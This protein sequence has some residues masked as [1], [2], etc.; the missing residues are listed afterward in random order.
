MKRSLR[1]RLLQ[2][3]H[4]K[5]GEELDADAIETVT[6]NNNVVNQPGVI[7][8]PGVIVDTPEEEEQINNEG[9]TSQQQQQDDSTT[10]SIWDNGTPTT[11]DNN[12]N[13]QHQ[14]GQTTQQTPQQQI[15]QEA[16][17]A[18]FP[19]QP[20]TIFKNQPPRAATTFALFSSPTRFNPTTIHTSNTHYLNN[21]LEGMIYLDVN[22][23]GIR[24]S[25][26][27]RSINALEFDTG[28][29]GVESTLVHCQSNEIVMGGYP[30][31][32]IV[33]V[34]RPN[35]GES[36][37][38]EA[39][40]SERTDAG[41]YNFELSSV[42]P[43][44]YYIMYKSPKDYRLNANILPLD[45]KEGSGECLPKG[46]EGNGYIKDVYEK[47]DLDWNGYCGRTVGCFEVG[48]KVRLF[49]Y[50]LFTEGSCGLC[51][52]YLQRLILTLLHPISHTTTQTTV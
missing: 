30:L 20:E 48:P 10:N 33:D 12:G 9:S 37:V 27:D 29:G 4:G 47:G 41:L 3:I 2:L 42:K 36:V 25:T 50:V 21:A 43:G 45:R 28:V 14:G 24:G 18:S 31:E 16:Y 15:S 32:S 49:I 39:L 34:S 1:L 11:L 17:E 19:T 40:Q 44:R 23:D 35:L 8:Q 51:W 22:G 5:E 52:A 7:Q 38:T 46:G 6:P 26:L 13:N